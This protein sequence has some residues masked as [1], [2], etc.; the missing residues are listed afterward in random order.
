MYKIITLYYKR[1]GRAVGKS[2]PMLLSEASEA[3]LMQGEVKARR[4]QDFW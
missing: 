2:S 1:T 4:G 3:R